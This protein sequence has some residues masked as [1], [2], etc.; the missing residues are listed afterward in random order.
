LITLAVLAC[1]ACGVAY[2]REAAR[3]GWF[4]FAVFGWG[5]F[6]LTFGPYSAGDVRSMLPTTQALAY[7]HARLRP[8]GFSLLTTVYPPPGGTGIGKAVFLTS[9]LPAYLL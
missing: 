2:R 9:S 6:I 5:Y 1:S 3:A 7:A 8:G 4:G